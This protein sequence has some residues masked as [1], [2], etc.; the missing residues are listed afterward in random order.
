MG[1]RLSVSV[2]S[3]LR[4]LGIRGIAGGRAKL[5]RCMTYPPLHSAR[6]IWGFASIKLVAALWLEGMLANGPL[7][8]L[9]LSR[10]GR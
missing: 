3:G 6:F 9:K 7:M 1:L 4:G 5:P 10:H 8:L 2:V